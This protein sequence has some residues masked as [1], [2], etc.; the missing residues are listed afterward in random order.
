MS[1]YVQHQSLLTLIV[2]SLLQTFLVLFTQQACNVCSQYDVCSICVYVPSLY[3]SWV[4]ILVWAGKKDSRSLDPGGFLWPPPFSGGIW[5][6]S[7]LP[8]I[9][10]LGSYILVN[11]LLAAVPWRSLS[12]GHWHTF[13]RGIPDFPTKRS[14][15]YI[16]SLGYRAPCQVRLGWGTVEKEEPIYTLTQKANVNQAHH[17]DVFWR[18]CGD[19]PANGHPQTA[20]WMPEFCHWHLSCVSR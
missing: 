4:L 3:Q 16:Q 14:C 10:L 13:Q 19:P 20:C 6:P 2:D 18:L 11:I 1:S 17:Q 7:H 8:E 15:S 12:L 9:S 5:K